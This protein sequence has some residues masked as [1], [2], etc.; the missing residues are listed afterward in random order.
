ME[1]GSLASTG[2]GARSIA[3]PPRTPSG[4][5]PQM[6]SG[7]IFGLTAALYG[8]ITFEGGRW[9]SVISTTIRCCA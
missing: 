4:E 1:D 8:E 9:S 5:I 6:E 3:A 7:V 2:C